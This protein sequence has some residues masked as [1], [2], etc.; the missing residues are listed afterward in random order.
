MFLFFEQWVGNAQD[1]DGINEVEK[2]F[3][4]CRRDICERWSPSKV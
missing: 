3:W 2:E 4:N 1:E